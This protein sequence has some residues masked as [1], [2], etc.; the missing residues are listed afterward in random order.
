MPLRH[1]SLIGI[2]AVLAGLAGCSSG[3]LDQCNQ[4]IEVANQ[5]VTEVEA[6]TSDSAPRDTDTAAFVS[7]TEAAQQAATQLESIDLTDEQLQGYRQRFIKLYVAT[8]DATE[9]LVT[10]VEEQDPI[11][12]EDAYTDLETATSQEQ[13]LVEEINQYCQS[14]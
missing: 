9:A 10:A 3:K 7:I 1:H 8:G 12:A 6:V 5:A 14:S 2:A 11:G 13:P 4:L